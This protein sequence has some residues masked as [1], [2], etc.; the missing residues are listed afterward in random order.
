LTA[1][2]SEVHVQAFTESES[3]SNKYSVEILIFLLIWILRSEF[4]CLMS[5]VLLHQKVRL[6]STVNFKTQCNQ[7]DWYGFAAKKFLKVLL[8]AV[9]VIL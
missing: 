7:N 8:S 9:S 1:L 3:G 4:K 2:T 5:F 6:A